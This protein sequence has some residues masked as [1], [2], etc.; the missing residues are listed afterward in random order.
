[1]YSQL[2]AIGIERAR[3]RGGEIVPIFFW[4][5]SFFMNFKSP[6][7]NECSGLCEPTADTTFTDTLRRQSLVLS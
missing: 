4:D 6:V 3:T 5:P 1:M 7:Y 2:P